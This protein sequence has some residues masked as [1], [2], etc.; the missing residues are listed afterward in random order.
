MLGMAGGAA[1]GVIGGVVL[2][3]VLSGGDVSDGLDM[4]GLADGMSNLMDGSGDSGNGAGILD[5]LFNGG[6]SGGH[7]SFQQFSDPS[8]GLYDG[9][10]NPYLEPGQESLPYFD[11]SDQ[12]NSGAGTDPTSIFD[13]PDQYN[14]Y[15]QQQQQQQQQ[16]RPDYMHMAHEAYNKIH[17]AQQ[18]TQQPEQG[19]NSSGGVAPLVSHSS[20][21][22][23]TGQHVGYQQN[24][25]PA[26]VGHAQQPH[27]PSMSGP[28]YPPQ[29]NTFPGY[30]GAHDVYHNTAV[31]NQTT[32]HSHVYQHGQ[33][34]QLGASQQA[35]TYQQS[36]SYQPGP[37]YQ[38]SQHAQQAAHSQGTGINST[39]VMQF[40]KGALIAGGILAK[41][42]E[43]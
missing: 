40:A 15:D 28:Q 5:G 12:V 1:V 6:G 21:G 22:A 3:G 31:H 26:G 32:Q 8:N 29:H 19:S 35:Q 16:S 34:Y 33:T 37:T 11:P 4:S 24:G 27:A 14:P 13:Q 7:S 9:P 2:N 10:P 25:M 39:H 30:Q 17:Q 36:H 38:G 20:S 43:D 23:S 41:L 18:Q 42:N